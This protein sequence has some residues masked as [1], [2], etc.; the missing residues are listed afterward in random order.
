MPVG[1][2]ELCAAAQQV[3]PTF[4]AKGYE[5]LADSTDSNVQ[6]LIR[7][8]ESAYPAEPAKKILRRLAQIGVALV[9]HRFAI[10]E[11]IS[12]VGGS[13]E[14]DEQGEL[15]EEFESAAGFDAPD[16]DASLV[17]PIA[18]AQQ[19]LRS[20]AD[21]EVLQLVRP[22]S[23]VTMIKMRGTSP[24]GSA[25]GNF[26]WID[27]VG[28]W[29]RGVVR[30]E[31]CATLFSGSTLNARLLDHDHTRDAISLGLQQDSMASVIG[32][33]ERDYGID[34]P[35]SSIV[36][37]VVESAPPV[38]ERAMSMMPFR[39]GSMLSDSIC[40]DEPNDEARA[41]MRGRVEE[42]IQLGYINGGIFAQREDRRGR[43][44]NEAELLRLR[45]QHVFLLKTAA[46]FLSVE[47]Q[48]MISPPSGSEQSSNTRKGTLNYIC[49]ALD[50]ALTE[51]ESRIDGRFLETWVVYYDEEARV[52]I[53]V[54]PRDTRVIARMRTHFDSCFASC[55]VDGILRMLFEASVA[56]YESFHTDMLN[57]TDECE[58]MI[59]PRL[60]GTQKKDS[61]DGAELSRAERK[62]RSQYNV[63]QAGC[64]GWFLSL[65]TRGLR[66]VWRKIMRPRVT[67]AHVTVSALRIMN[68]VYRQASTYRRALR[69]TLAALDD[70]ERLRGTG[71]RNRHIADLRNSATERAV[72]CEDLQE[73]TSEIVNLAVNLSSEKYSQLLARLLWILLP[74]NFLILINALNSMNFVTTRT[75]PWK[76][77]YPTIAV[78]YFVVLVL[79]VVGGYRLRIF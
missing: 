52:I 1:W 13:P 14:V 43:A 56:N 55:G 11:A 2:K 37:R 79:V 30:A 5:A 71:S 39:R 68:L 47:A 4:A 78:L 24:S 59:A 53:T 8:F 22:N 32:K 69:G 77:G 16:E 34:L 60:Q 42:G 70:L 12:S 21:D 67:N 35:M 58:A 48:Q 40:G 66:S 23:G 46:P 44:R 36:K 73:A 9:G 10:L 31:R 49:L 19:R 57:L 51:G 26:T 3:C 76:Y 65:T 7:D 25:E 20:S 72:R 41:L 18:L 38:K 54:R 63:Q 28:L 74:F 15:V 27:V 33:L 45:R 29:S 61:E 17:G 64:C 62:R 6:A 50:T 75:I